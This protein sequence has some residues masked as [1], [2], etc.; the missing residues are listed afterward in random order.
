MFMVTRRSSDEV[1]L[2][3]AARSVPFVAG[4]TPAMREW[5][6][7]LV[8]RAR[9][10][11]VE[12]TGDDGLL[13]AMVRQVLQTGLEVE[14]TDHLGYEPHDPAGRGSGNS[15]NGTSRKTVITD[16]G[17]VEL[18]GPGH[19]NGT[20]DPQTVPKHQRR[21]D[22]LTGNVISLYAK[23]M[24]TADIQAHLLE[25]YG[26]EISRETISKITDVVVE[27]MLA[28]Q[29]R[30]LD[31]LYPVLL[32]DA[33]VI[34]VRDSQV[35]NR[36]VYVAIGVNLDGDR[37]VLGLWL[38]PSGGEGAKQWMTMLTELKNRGIADALIVCCDGLKGLPDAIRVTWPDATV[39]TCVVHMVRNS[40]RY[41]S[42]ANW[43]QITK[44]MRA[45]YT[46]PTVEAAEVR[47]AE[48][49]DNWRETYPAMISSWENAWG[50]FVPF[51]EFPAALRKI[52][53]TTNAIESLNA[54]F[55]KAVRHR[56]HF[57]NEQAALKVL[58]LVATTRRKNRENMTG[59]TNGWKAILN[60]LTVHYGDRITN[61]NR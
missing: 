6:E 3:P 5:A 46:A 13:T 31:R 34:K 19:R 1:S 47:F 51:L 22:G 60:E 37:D 18:A 20:F 11:G 59:R 38:G 23:G 25:I 4:D 29:H 16:V 21:L 54:R 50:E 49:A 42:K 15:R 45:I 40:L 36:P 41:A 17:D 48:F 32:I 52:V 44:E 55:R 7:Q 61:I 43:G 12:L 26:T 33:I 57:P 9:A 24:T 8:A 56:G 2:M 53:Y 28:W 58:Y 35:A 39:Q 14:L 27:D 30:P 10:E